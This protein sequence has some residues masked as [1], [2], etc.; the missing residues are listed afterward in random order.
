MADAIEEKVLSADVYDA[1]KAREYAELVKIIRGDGDLDTY[2]GLMNKERRV[3]DTVDRVVNDARLRRSA[4]SSLPD[5]R[6]SQLVTRTLA[7]V[8]EVYH[9]L[10]RVRRVSDVPDVFTRRGR[11][12]YVGILIIFASLVIMVVRAST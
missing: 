5:M 9:D 11:L 1:P 4:A 12:L 3:L 6:V 2:S 7:V 10:L 8:V